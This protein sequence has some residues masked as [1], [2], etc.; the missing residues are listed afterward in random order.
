MTSADP[1]AF[2]P[3]SIELQSVAD[4]KITSVSVYP[5][6]AEVTRVY[7][8][9]VQT[10]QNQVYISGL[11]NVLEPESLRVEGRGAATIH[12]VTL[13]VADEVSQEFVP[14]FSPKLAELLSTREDKEDALTRCEQALSSLRQYL[15]SLTVQNLPVTQLESV[16]HQYETTGARLDARKKELTRELQRIDTEIAAENAQ[17]AVPPE[18]HWLRNMAAIGVFAQTPGNVEIAL[19][20]A[21]PYASWTAFYDIRVDMDAKESPVKLIYKAA[22]KQNTGES[23]D[24]VPLQLETSTPTFGLG[25]PKLPE[26]VE[27]KHEE[28]AVMSTG[29]VNATFRV[30]GLVTIPCDNAAH[31]LTIVELRPQA[32]MSWVAVPK[33]EAK[34][35][36]TAHIT[37]AS[38][39]TLLSG[40]ANVYVDGSFIARSTVPSV[41]PQESFDC[42]LGLDPS[43]RITYP[44]ISKQLS[45]SSFY[46]KSAT[47]G[48]TQRITVHNTKSVP[49]DGLRIVDQIPVP[50][51]AQVKVKLVQPALP[52]GE[53]EGVTGKGAEAESNAG[54]GAGAKG[55]GK[56]SAS[57]SVSKGVVAQ[58]DGGD[59]TDRRVSWVCAVPAQGKINLT[60]EW[61]VTVS[62]ADAQVVGL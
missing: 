34:T 11:P 21:V 7:K 58:W 44:P 46:K 22:I 12:D 51:N 56:Q 14:M 54:A 15:D 16:L 41:S 26:V 38:E 36:L 57:V 25:V 62:P 35:H 55:K 18:D 49:V 4:S 3:T 17:M 61:T 37:N 2:E 39:Y 59:K 60:L 8:F 20:Y 52:L 31:N 19:I 1:P 27:M 43:I 42:P 32:V 5:T 28:A 13:S 10:G 50:R 45:Q 48:F 23:W 30:P 24:N 9:A 6:R 47:H 40:T 29:N 53:G 33:R